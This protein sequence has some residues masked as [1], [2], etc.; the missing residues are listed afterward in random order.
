[1]G[2]GVMSNAK[3]Q[4]KERKGVKELHIFVDVL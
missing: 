3:K 4:T 2:K 1:M